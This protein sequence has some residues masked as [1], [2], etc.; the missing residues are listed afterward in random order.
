MLRPFVRVCAVLP[1]LAIAAVMA[2]LAQGPAF[3]Q[4]KEIKIGLI[5]DQTGPFAGGGSM[6]SYQ[7]SKY[8]IDLFNERGGVEGYKVNAIY[9]DAQSKADVAVNEGERLINEQKVDM[10]MGVFSSAHCVPLS[11]KVEAA[12]KFW[13]ATICISS[14]VFK[15]KNMQYIFR[16]HLHSDQYG[17][18]SCDM[19]NEISKAKLGI[20]PKDLKVAIIHEDGPYGVG[21][22]SGN[23]SQC[24]K[25]GMQIVHKEG[26][27]ASSADLS[28][29]VSKLRRA[30]PDV[31]L[32]TGYNPDITLFMRQAKEAGL[33][34]K[35]LIGHGA[36]Y[37]QYEQIAAR[38]GPDINWVF[39]VDSPDP[40]LIDSKKL[41]VAGADELKAEM[42]KRFKAETGS[43]NPSNT[44]GIAFNNT[45]I[46]LS[47]VLPRAI[48]KHGGIDTEALRK[49]AAETDIPEGGTLQG[50]GV[51]FNPPG[52]EMANQNARSYPI[53]AQYVDGK[54]Y[55]VYPIALKS[56]DPVMPLPA[57]HGLGGN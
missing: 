21:V 23:E 34:V 52:H 1:L 38:L 19:L 10:L 24:K 55:V 5:F 28:S 12:K 25:H 32:H 4:T 9:A 14:A 17:W 51:K 37:G 50:Y 8:A 2:A 56:A 3:A 20:E 13:W 7:G 18:V 47:D 33:K 29:M 53:V 57:T 15:N 41:T 43:D 54:T 6:A 48:R 42:K 45:W 26:Y 27:A 31:L 30:R 11:A 22:A 49:A 16:S 35:A 44:I 36:G 46:F 40:Q 39:N